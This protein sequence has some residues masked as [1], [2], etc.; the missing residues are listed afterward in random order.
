MKK[1][2]EE[3]HQGGART[4]IMNAEDNSEGN[5]SNGSDDQES[6]EDEMSDI[7]EGAFGVNKDIYQSTKQPSVNDPKLW[8]VRVKRNHERIAVL[9]LINKCIDFHR[10]Q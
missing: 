2:R 1:Q 10:R 4:G 7:G 8:Q 5:S 9:A 3:L 6:F